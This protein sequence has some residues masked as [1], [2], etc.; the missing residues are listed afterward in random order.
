MSDVPAAPVPAGAMPDDLTAARHTAADAP[1]VP[2]TAA[3]GAIWVRELRA[4]MRGKKAFIFIS[5]YL[6]LLVGLMWVAL[7][8]VDSTYLG[9][10]EQ[11]SVGRAIFAAVVVIETLVVVALAPPYT[12]GSISQER[13]KQT[14]DLLAVTPVSSLGI[15]LGKLVSGLAYLAL[16]VG[17]SIPLASVAFIFGGVEF[18]TLL[19]AYLLIASS[20][21]GVGSIG[22]ASSALMRRTQPATVGAF[23]LAGLVIVGATGMYVILSGIAD[24]KGQPRPPDALLYLNPFVAMADLLCAETGQA[25]VVDLTAGL[26]PAAGGNWLPP[27]EPAPSAGWLWPR[28]LLAWGGMTALMLVLASQSISSTRRWR[29][30]RRAP[31]TEPGA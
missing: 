4:R 6:G 12:A 15:V 8:A 2:L 29:P 27:A 28:S 20:A 31:A 17:V 30:G 18:T 1:K 16:L 14:F 13:E 9:A 10:L 23:I 3:V 7:R 26:E 11:L 24:S 25:C 22:V 5:V 19:L 21:L